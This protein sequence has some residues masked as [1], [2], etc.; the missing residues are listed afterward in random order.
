MREQT[1]MHRPHSCIIY[2]KTWWVAKR[3]SPATGEQSQAHPG[4]GTV[5][6][7][8]SGLPCPLPPPPLACDSSSV[9]LPPPCASSCTA[10]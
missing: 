10:R 9:P 8:Y 6:V 1:A 2:R 4:H 5:A 3:P 7:L